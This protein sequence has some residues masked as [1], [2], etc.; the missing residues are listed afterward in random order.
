M[1][2]LGRYGQRQRL[3]TPARIL[4]T[5][6]QTIKRKDALNNLSRQDATDLSMIAYASPYFIPVYPPRHIAP[7]TDCH[8]ILSS[9]DFTDVHSART[10]ESG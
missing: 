3:S 5:H 4:S 6:V 8:S 2:L 10:V 9:H 7:K 1:L